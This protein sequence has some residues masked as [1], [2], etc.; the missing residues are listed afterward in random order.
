MKEYDILD[1]E[2]D[3]KYRHVAIKWYQKY[4]MACVDG[5]NQFFIEPKP[6]KDW[7]ETFNNA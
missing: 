6:A 4:H 2:F 7:N 1:L 5:T 3:K